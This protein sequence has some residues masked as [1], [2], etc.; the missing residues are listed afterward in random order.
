MVTRRI[1]VIGSGEVGETLANGFLKHGYEVLRASRDPKKLA[2]WKQKAGA[3]ASTGTNAEA[4]RFGDVIVLAVK[5]DAAESAVKTC[6]ADAL[7]DKVVI[8]AC[9]PIAEAPPE[10]GVLTFFTGPN[11][12]LMERLQKLAPRARFVKAF[13]SVGAP[14]MVNPDFGGTRPTMF[15]CGNDA[16]ARTTVREILDQFGWETE[17]LG[18]AIAARAIEPLAVLW[19]IPGFLHDRWNHAFKLLRK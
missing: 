5:G 12:S 3:R 19:C 10:Q 18:G 9:N 2:G 16:K 15:L 13:S 4:A 1:G 6:G 8:D 7:G 14:H 17:D 11:E